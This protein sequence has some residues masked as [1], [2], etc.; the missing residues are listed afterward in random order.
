MSDVGLVPQ[1]IGF[2]SVWLL[3]LSVGLTACTA[4]CLPFMGTWAIGQG[5]GGIMALRHT[6]MFAAGKVMAY[7]F[8]GVLAGLLGV[9]LEEAL[10]GSTGHVFIGIAS[11]LAGFWLLAMGRAN[12]L[13]TVA[14]NGKGLP[15]FALGFA[16]SLT[17]CAPLAALL[18]ACA[19]SG[20]PWLGLGYGVAFGL[21]AA[22]TP[23]FIVMPLIGTF[24][25]KLGEGRPWM[26]RMLRY[27]AA[28]ALVLLGLRRIWLVL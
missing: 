5:G 20:D 19:M 3:G 17:P 6:G 27:G 25:K 10:A 15:P 16:L 22:L 23:L 21:G 8:L 18:A 13:C 26:G 12:K 24:G 14:Q 9:W 7:G 1:E 11:I 4:V 2:F 28:G